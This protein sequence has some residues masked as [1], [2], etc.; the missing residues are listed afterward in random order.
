MLDIFRKKAKIIIY[1]TA[2][3]FIVGMAI[4]GI[5]GLFERRSTSIGKIAG[6]NISYQ[7]Y[8]QW[9]QNTYQNYMAENPDVQPDEQ[10]FERLND[11]TWQQLVQKILFDQEIKRRRIRISDNQV[12]DK[13]KND[14]PAFI[15]EA[16]VFH[17]DGVFD[18]E[19]YL[20]TLRT[21]LTPNGQPLDLS[22]LEYHVRDQ[23]PYELLFE[24]IKNEVTITEAD[25]EQ[26]YIMKNDK[27][28]AKV[29]FFDP[30]KITQVEV[31]DEE[32]EEYYNS[33]RD[34]FKKKPSVRYDYV[35]FQ[36]QPSERDQNEVLELAMAIYKQL[37][38]GA[39]FSAMALEYSQ[40]PGNAERGGDLDYFG[41]GRMVPEFEETA[42]N[43]EI[44]EISEPVKTQFGWHIIKLTDKRIGADNE[45]E[46]RASHILL[47]V[48]A[49]E[50][51]K[52]EIKDKAEEFRQLVVKK[53]I[54][55]AAEESELT[56][57]ES[58]P[59]EE[60]AQ[61]IQ[62]VG[63]FEDLVEFGFAKRVGA[64]PDVKESANG[65]LYVLQIVEKLPERYDELT[66]VSNRI[67]T[68]LETNKKREL[69]KERA[70]EFFASK[71]PEEFL[72]AATREG[73]EIIEA[74]DVTIDRSIPRI[75]K[76]DELNEA[77]LAANSGEYTPLIKGER[78]AYLAFVEER[79]KPDMEYFAERKEFL[80]EEMSEREK[81]QHLNEWYRKLMEDAEIVDNR[82][83]FF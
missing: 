49:S 64:V 54:R 69:V 10:T 21:G 55:E 2:F 3:V 81:N 48:E 74:Q 52:L 51:T 34:E 38:E 7:E 61:F 65:D 72:P 18:S 77:I 29:I 62:G 79:S 19:L 31:T 46:V 73:W 53:G 30:T 25:V 9:L 24:K 60:N 58:G 39:D 15:K 6:R 16:E 40:D 27:A 23:L 66:I 28:N 20:Y 63:R 37:I 80:M 4:M 12:I 68:N 43:M 70:E 78:G 47:R 45:P 42:F 8:M 59:F 22:W 13:M 50:L 57:M 5:S 14:P 75:G 83:L 32:I 11:Q 17:T 71:E 33:N 36:M 41:R 82:H 44:G 1:V 26:D 56:V 67:K 76:V 35:R